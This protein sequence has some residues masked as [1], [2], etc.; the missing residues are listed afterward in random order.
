MS[1]LGD[2]PP[3]EWPEFADR[4]TDRHEREGVDVRRQPEHGLHFVL[5]ADVIGG[6][7]GAEP[8]RTAGEDDVLDRGIN[9]R[10]ANT[11]LI[12]PLVLIVRLELRQER[13][14]RRQ[15]PHREAGNQDD[16]RIAHVFPQIGAPSPH[17]ISA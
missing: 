15:F 2:G 13:F 12:T 10:A 7:D 3:R 8:Q 17:P 9:A 14:A 6:D 11:I 4:K 16:R 5:E 1:H